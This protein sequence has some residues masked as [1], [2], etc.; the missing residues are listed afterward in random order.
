MRYKSNSG[1]TLYRIN[2]YIEESNEIFMDNAPKYTGYNIEI[3]SVARITRT[4]FLTAKP[5]SK[6]ENK[7]EIENKFN[8]GKS[9]IRRV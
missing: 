3:Q 6:W 8:K 5:H 1:A 7:V 4:D 2:R 9:K